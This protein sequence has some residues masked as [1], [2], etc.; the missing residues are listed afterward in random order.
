[1]TRS[2][3]RPKSSS[4][5]AL[6]QLRTLIFTGQLGAG[7]DHLES[8]LAE[9]LG[10]SRT[11]VREALLVLEGQGL[12]D[13]RPRKGVRIRPLSPQDMEEIYDVLTALE[14]LAA[15]NAARAGFREETLTLLATAIDQMDAALGVENREDWARADD[16]FHAEL[17]RLGGNA[18][19]QSIAA[20]MSDQVRRARLV[21]LHMRPVPTE[22]NKDHRALLELIRQ[23]DAQ[24]A[25][26][27]HRRHRS[28]AKTLLIALLEKHHLN[29]L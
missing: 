25:E 29:T 3:A 2:V 13:V 1:M 24:G 18:R 22:S 16:A 19:A 11:P 26:A 15:A 12:V 8:E 4:S 6:E 10:M 7:T 9:N 5:V 21:T 23:G 27:L 17:M 20:M 28:Q 14:S